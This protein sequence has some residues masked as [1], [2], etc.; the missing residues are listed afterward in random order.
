MLLLLAENPATAA[1]DDDDNDDEAI[2]LL[3]PPV[4]VMCVDDD[5]IIN[6]VSGRETSSISSAVRN[7]ILNNFSSN[8]EI[9]FLVDDA[10]IGIP[11][12]SVSFSKSDR[13]LDVVWSFFCNN[14]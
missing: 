14:S 2:M 6:G 10:S 12:A 13:D 11:G 8:C 9:D 7:S 3:L 4:P 5:I 1:A